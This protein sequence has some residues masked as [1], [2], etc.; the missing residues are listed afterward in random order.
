M[1]RNHSRRDAAPQARRETDVSRGATSSR[2]SARARSPPPSF[3]S[4]A[5]RERRAPPRSVRARWPITLTINGQRHQLKVEPRVTLLDAMR[6]RLDITGMKRVCDRG[7]CGACTVIIDG[8]TFYSC[9]LLAIE[10]QGQN[11][12][13]VEGLSHRRALHPVQ[14]A[15]CDNDALDVRLLHARVRHGHGRAAGEDA[16]A[17][18]RASQTR[19]RRQHLPLRHQCRR[20]RRGAEDEGGDRV[21]SAPH[22]TRRT[23]A[24]T[25]LPHR[26]GAR[27]PGTARPASHPKYAWPEKVAAARHAHQSRRRAAEDHRPR[28]VFVRHLAP[29]HDLRQDPAL[30]ARARASARASTSPPRRKRRASERPSRPSSPVRR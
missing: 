24:P 19:A 6:T 12:R 4:A 23:L 17:Y 13:T 7:S 10:A 8:R 30:A 11:I 22:R 3:R 14:Q 29:R 2:P 9:S 16:D 18:R 27:S 21:A 25:H 20:P 15:F 28:Q 5:R 26:A 1:A